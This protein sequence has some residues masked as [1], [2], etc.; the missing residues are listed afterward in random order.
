MLLPATT[1]LSFV[2]RP[3]PKPD[4]RPSMAPH[5]QQQPSALFQDDQRVQPELEASIL[6]F[7]DTVRKSADTIVTLRQ[8]NTRLKADVAAARSEVTTARAETSTVRAEGDALRASLAEL[9]T[10]I[11][12]LSATVARLEAERLAVDDERLAAE[13]ERAALERERDSLQQALSEHEAAAA[14]VAAHAAAHAATT[15]PREALEALA[16]ELDQLKKREQDFLDQ[17]AKAATD[18]ERQRDATAQLQAELSE[19]IA[20]ATTLRA[21]LDGVRA[22]LDD[23]LRGVDRQ[24]CSPGHAAPAH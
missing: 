22:E 7:W 8:E 20:E 13:R 5:P 4:R 18:Y 1:A 17:L 24:R 19:R 9:E 21:E 12:D 23:A 10:T 16:A 15:V 14:Q 2:V 11:A 6:R 3:H